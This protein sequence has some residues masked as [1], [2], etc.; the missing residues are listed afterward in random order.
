MPAT[1]QDLVNDMMVHDNQ[2][3]DYDVPLSKGPSCTPSANLGCED[4]LDYEILTEMVSQMADS[5][6]YRRIDDRV[7]TDRTE[8]QTKHWALQI[9]CLVLAYLECHAKDAGDGMPSMQPQAPSGDDKQISDISLVDVFSVLASAFTHNA[10][11]CVIFTVQF[12]A[13]FD[14]YLEILA[15]VEQR[16]NAVL[17]RNTPNWRMWNVC[18]AC[19]Y[20]LKDE[21]PLEFSYLASIDGN[22]SLKR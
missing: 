15:W 17:T 6:G 12:S 14:A 3:M 18:P 19:F 21:P 1:D 10:K 8:A 7:R 20:K 5:K 4:K 13:A 11:L 2:F 22:N 16:V 9:D